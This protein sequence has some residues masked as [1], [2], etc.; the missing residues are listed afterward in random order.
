M[1]V[2]VSADNFLQLFVGWEGVGLCSY[3]LINFWFTRL[4]ANKAALKALIINR[5][6]DFAFVL[7]LLLIFD[8]FQTLDFSVIFSLVPYFLKKQICITGYYL[9]SID[10]IC[11]FLFIG[12]VSKSAQLGLHT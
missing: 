11:F 8:V 4:Q 6:G 1:L 5:V 2:L 9:N 3:L 7:G 10:V 12:C